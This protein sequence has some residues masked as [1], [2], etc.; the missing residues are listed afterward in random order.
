MLLPIRFQCAEV[1]IPTGLLCIYV[2]TELTTCL[3]HCDLRK[4]R[5][6]PDSLEGKSCARPVMSKLSLP[7]RK[8]GSVVRN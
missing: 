2:H 8:F 3:P 4:M 5:L 6:A 1:W 7:P